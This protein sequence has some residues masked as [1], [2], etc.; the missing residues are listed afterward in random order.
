[1]SWQYGKASKRKPQH[2]TLHAI[3]LG[4][5][6]DHSSLFE[7][8]L[9]LAKAAGLQKSTISKHVQALRSEGLVTASREGLDVTDAGIERLR[10]LFPDEDFD[11]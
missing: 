5:D 1:L 2:Q 7:K 4:P 11:P 9:D 8:Q 10:Q 3:Y 6:G